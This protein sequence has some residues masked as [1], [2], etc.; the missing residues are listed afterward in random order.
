MALYSNIDQYRQQLSGS[1]SDH[2]VSTLLA[3]HHLPQFITHMIEVAIAY[4]VGCIS[5]MLKGVSNHT[6][7]VI[8]RLEGGLQDEML[9]LLQLYMQLYPLTI[10]NNTEYLTAQLDGLIHRLVGIL[11]SVL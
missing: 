9:S 10:G 1:P 6:N 8:L 3:V 5:N 11:K 2:F 4:N 7:S